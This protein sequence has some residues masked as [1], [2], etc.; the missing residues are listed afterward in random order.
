MERPEL[1]KILDRFEVPWSEWGK[2]G[3]KTVEQLLHELNFEEVV[4]SIRDDRLLREVRGVIVNVFYQ[5]DQQLLRLF[6]SHQVFLDGTVRVREA[7]LIPGEKL[8]K[9]ETIEAGGRRMLR[10]E[11]GIK[12][13]LPLTPQKPIEKGPFISATYPGLWSKYFNSVLS[14]SLTRDLYEPDGYIERQPDKTSFFKWEF[15]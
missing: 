11:L 13:L 3:A 14:T 5:R 7:H 4:L 8:L 10:E 12:T 2:G 6:E 15:A 9:G 1:I